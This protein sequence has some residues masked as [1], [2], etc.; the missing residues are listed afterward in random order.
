MICCAMAA[1]VLAALAACRGFVNGS[2]AWP[3][4]ARWAIV[5]LGAGLLLASGATLAANRLDRLHTERGGLAA[6]L[7]LHICGEHSVSPAS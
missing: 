6:V 4:P 2:M 7:L 1:L 3:P 5:V